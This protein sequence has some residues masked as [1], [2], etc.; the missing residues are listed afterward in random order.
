MSVAIS[1]YAM[2]RRI[3]TPILSLLGQES[4]HKLF[5]NTVGITQHIP[6]WKHIVRWTHRYESPALTRELFGLQFKNPVGLAAGFDTNAEYIDELSNFG[7]SFIEI[8][9][10]SPA[11]Q[12]GAQKP[13]VVRSMPDLTLVTKL[14][15]RNKGV[16]N[17]ISNLQKSR[18]SVIICGSVIPNASSH[19]DDDII[20][21]YKKCFSLLYDFVDILTINVSCPN[22][23]GV[24]TLQDKNAVS[25]VLE[26]LIDL[27]MC[28]DS[29]KPILIKVSPDIPYEQLDEILD[30]C[31]MSG[32][33]GIIAGNYMRMTSELK[34]A[35]SKNSVPKSGFISG[36]PV[37]EK[38]LALVKHIHEHTKGR[39]P[40]IGCGG[41]LTPEQGKEMLESGASLIQLYSGIVFNS[42]KLVKKTLKAI[43]P[44][45]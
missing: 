9:S 21:D 32:I 25:E 1:Y 15:I 34:T 11:A 45:Q 6:I 20:N 38:S 3:I 24:Q 27:R 7:F 13:R 37:Y 35:L 2:Y 14:G 23:N 39:F 29:Y 18:H 26:P 42:T 36:A 43:A 10:V 19:K 17:A 44:K 31:M 4:S 16:S 5:L 30:Y 22:E 8:G 12:E 41:I 40:I 33:D 28:Y